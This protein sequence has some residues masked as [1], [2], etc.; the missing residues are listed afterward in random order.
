MR[1]LTFSFSLMFTMLIGA[2]NLL[3]QDAQFSQFYGNPLYLNPALAGN[4]I[5]PRI[6]LNYRNQWPAIPASFVTY[7]V[8]ADRYVEALSGSVA[9]MA[10]SDNAGGGIL[11]NNAIS[12]IYSYRLEIEREFVLT[13]GFQAS[14]QQVSLDWNR[15]IFESQITD[16]NGPQEPVPSDKA[17]NKIFPDFSTGFVLGMYY[18]YFVGFAAHHLT[19]PSLSVYDAD[20][21][22]YDPNSKQ[23]LKITAHAGALFNLQRPA[24]FLDPDK[25]PTISPN[26]LYQQQG[27]FKQ[28][29]VGLYTTLY[30]VTIGFWYRYAFNN[31]DAF[32]ALLGFEYEKIKLGYTY[33][34]T[35]SGLSNATG[36][37]HEISLAWVLPC[38]EIGK[39]SKLKAIKVTPF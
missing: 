14:F 33:D 24:R 36:G 22:N 3:A 39:N 32:I 5:C 17:L 15:L 18:R 31:S 13:T 28:L 8:S 16:P 38:N 12:G 10:F 23:N 21:V 34:Y 29:N 26:I 35:V 37:A 25:A 2:A 6:T 30:P 27:A 11:T 1:Q 4:K 20:G 9:L 7:S 19:Q